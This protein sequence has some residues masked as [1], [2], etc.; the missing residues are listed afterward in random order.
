MLSRI[1]TFRTGTGSPFLFG[2]NN[3]GFLLLIKK[4]IVRYF[5]ISCC[6][7]I[8]LFTKS[9]QNQFTDSIIN[10]FIDMLIILDACYRFSNMI[11]INRFTIFSCFNLSPFPSF[12][13]I[14][15]WDAC[16]NSIPCAKRPSCRI[17]N[18]LIS[19]SGFCNGFADLAKYF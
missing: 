10:N 13:L 5:I 14:L 8:E 7:N 9:F 11:I 4:E 17:T 6:I 3:A 16:Q 1:L 12:K 18:T 19:F 2:K 15:T